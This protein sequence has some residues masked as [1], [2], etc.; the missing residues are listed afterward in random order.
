M[1]KYLNKDFGWE[2]VDGHQ[3][4]GIIPSNKKLFTRLKNLA[5]VGYNRWQLGVDGDKHRVKPS[6]VRSTSIKIF[7]Y[8]GPE[9]RPDGLPL[10]KSVRVERGGMFTVG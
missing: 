1:P 8:G 4:W 6:L 2:A 5:L 3:A 7:L 9:T 10:L